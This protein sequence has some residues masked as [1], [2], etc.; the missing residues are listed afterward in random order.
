MKPA[1]D[2]VCSSLSIAFF[3]KT[4]KILIHQAFILVAT[5]RLDYCNSLSRSHPM[6]NL[7]KLQYIL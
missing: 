1:P 7:C 5:S 4:L 2:E 6:F 3:R